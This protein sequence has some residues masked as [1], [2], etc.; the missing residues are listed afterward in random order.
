[1]CRIPRCRGI[2]W[3]S[4]SEF[5]ASLP[6]FVTIWRVNRAWERREALFA[7]RSGT[8]GPRAGADFVLPEESAR[9]RFGRRLLY[10]LTRSVPPLLSLPGFTTSLHYEP[11]TRPNRERT[12]TPSESSSGPFRGEARFE[13]LD[14]LRSRSGPERS[15]P[16]GKERLP[17][18]HAR[19]TLQIVTKLGDD[20]GRTPNKGARSGGGLLIQR[21][22][23]PEPIA[24]S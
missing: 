19:F 16:G 2:S 9:G 7:S 12:R 1:M 17:E 11:G 22:L 6:S 5:R 4:R 18:F 14:R 15:T 13:I 10:S 20:D 3:P 24:A 21:P 23:G 8:L